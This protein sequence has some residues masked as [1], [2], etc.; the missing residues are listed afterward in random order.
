MNNKTTLVFVAATLTFAGFATLVTA[1]YGDF[2]TQES[3]EWTVT[4]TDVDDFDCL[5]RH[6][7]GTAS[8]FYDDVFVLDIDCDTDIE[9][10]DVVLATE[11]Y[12]G[13]AVGELV[14]DDMTLLLAGTTTDYGFDVVRA[15]ADEDGR[16]DADDFVFACDT[17]S[18]GVEATDA[19]FTGDLCIALTDAGELSAGDLVRTGDDV[20]DDWFEADEGGYDD[21]QI[22]IFDADGD[23]AFQG[24][25]DSDLMWLVDVAGGDCDEDVLPINS[26][27]I[28][29]DGLNFGTIVTEGSSAFTGTLK[30]DLGDLAHACLDEN[31]PATCTEIRV[32]RHAAG[33]ASNF[34][35]DV[36]IYDLDGSTDITQYDIV[37]ASSGYDGSAVGEL[38]SDDMTLLLGDD[39]GSFFC[40][41]T[42]VTVGAGACNSADADSGTFQT[43]VYDVNEDGTYNTD[44]TVVF[45]AAAAPADNDPATLVEVV[46]TAA[47]AGG[48]FC[49]YL[50][51]YSDAEAGEFVRTGDDILDDFAGDEFALGDDAQIVYYDSD[52]NSIF[53]GESSDRLWIDLT[54]AGLGDTVPRYSIELFG[55]SS[56]FGMQVGGDSDDFVLRLTQLDSVDGI[57]VVRHNAGTASNFFDDVFVL[58][59]GGPDYA[60]GVIEQFDL[61]IATQGYDGTEVGG[62]IEDD[63]TLLQ[64]S[65]CAT[66]ADTECLSSE[67]VIIDANEDDVY[68]DEDYVFICDSDTFAVTVASFTGDF[69]IAMT[70]A[71]DLS[72]GDLVRTGD[73]VFN[74]FE[75]Q[76][77]STDFDPSDATFCFY[78]ADNDESGFFEGDEDL[79]WLDPNDLTDCDDAVV[80]L[81]NVQLYGDFSTVPGGGG[82]VTTRT[83]TATSTVTNTSTNT[84]SVTNTV[85]TSGVPPT[86]GVNPTGSDS[87]SE[88]DDDNNSTP[89]FELVALVAAL[90]VALILVRRKL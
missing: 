83:N 48:A 32:F 65:D 89:G 13:T 50:T 7:A 55:E 46:A 54:G 35:D 51:S 15:D 42:I 2:V 1:D 70:E 73:D 30:V 75:G 10:Y 12:D 85:S 60:D 66:D 43:F 29:G 59:V 20:L 80:E 78:D 14:A 9:Q 16:V 88:T 67:V 64:G 87:G 17:A 27:E 26:I 4:L 19:S 33:T 24:E 84:T 18:G 68:S 8:N 22:C 5:V 57:G 39:E 56:E 37:L 36:V 23:G 6:N 49:I 63:M 40:D 38:V 52:S 53:D 34:F 41:V 3:S 47:S 45:C 44:D 71:G 31:G 25:E 74:D 58:E 82:G 72:P 21:A 77:W 69:C 11:G 61:V 90:G 28:W 79:A 62:L 81:Y 76:E 86:T